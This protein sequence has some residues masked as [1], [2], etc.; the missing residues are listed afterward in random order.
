MATARAPAGPLSR[1][2][3]FSVAPEIALFSLGGTIATS[4]QP[5][6]GSSPVAATAEGLLRSLDGILD[7]NVR[8]H[9]F[10]LVP[11]GD[12]TTGDVIELSR[13]VARA[14]EAGASGAVVT[15]GTN[16]LEETAFLLDHLIPAEAPVVVTGAMRSAGA[17]GADGDANLLA[18]L[19]VAASPLAR[20]IG[21]LVAFNDEVH[22]ARFVAKTHSTSTG[23][24]R[25]PNAGPLGWVTEGRVRIPLVPRRRSRV[26]DLPPGV[27]ELPAVGLV[28]LSLGDDGALLRS[29]AQTGFSG[30][31]VEVFGAGHASGRTLAPLAD[32][33]SAMPVVFASRT[34]AGELYRSSS[35][36]RGSERDLLAAGLISA[37]SLDGLKARLLLG[38]LLAEGAGTAVIAERF[39]EET[40]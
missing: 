29:L 38:L 3:A 7:I 39:A 20:G 28:R 32:L 34:G 17:P 1:R 37:A 27:T 30:L 24:F 40:S 2:D 23:A 12:L 26:V 5:T 11:S 35:Q 15:Q 25:S 21:T 13:A 10:R 22:A 14:I 16:T 18:A 19:R 9:D 33:A 6:G 36:F 4:W 8:P 31:V